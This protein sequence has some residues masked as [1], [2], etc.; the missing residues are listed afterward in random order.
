MAS[1][2]TRRCS[3]RS[4]GILDIERLSKISVLGDSKFGSMIR[5]PETRVSK[6][7]V[8]SSREIFVS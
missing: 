2:R 1:S 5:L 6:S 8:L 7:S 4:E 3:L